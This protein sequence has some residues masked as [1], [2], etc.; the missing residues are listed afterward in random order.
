M[1]GRSWLMSLRFVWSGLPALATGSKCWRLGGPAF[2]TT[3]APG[4]CSRGSN[5]WV[6]LAA[7][8][9]ASLTTWSAAGC[10]VVLTSG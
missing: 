7:A 9:S 1:H 3:S 6:R 5:C 8:T 2:L 10:A 4:H